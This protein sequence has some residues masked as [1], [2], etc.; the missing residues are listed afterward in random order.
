MKVVVL[1]SLAYSL[2]NFRATLLRAMAEQG[3]QIL[4]CAPDED[5]DVIPTLAANG[6]QFRTIPMERAGTNPLRDLKTLYHLVRLFRVERPDVILAYTQKP[7]I[8]GGMAARLA[9]PNARFYAMVSGLGHAFTAGGGGR[10]LLR[11][12][13]IALFRIA[14][15]RA[16]CIFVFNDCDAGEMRRLHI[17][18]AKH[19]VARVAGSGIDLERFARQPVPSGPPTFLMVARILRD[20]GVLEFIEAAKLIRARHPAARFQLLG[21]LDTGARGFRRVELEERLRDSGVDYLGDTRDV[22]PFL[23][24]STI[25]VLPSYYREGLPRT[26]L[27]AMATGRAIITTDMHGCRET[28]I[29][30]FNGILVQPRDATAL[31]QAMEDLVADPARTMEMGKRSRWLAAR[32]FDVHR[33]NDMLLTEMFDRGTNDQLKARRPARALNDRRALQFALAL[34]LG[35][36]LLPLALL[37]AIAAAIA[38]GGSVLLVQQ[39]AGKGATNFGLI[40]FRTM[41]DL[42]DAEGQL[43][44]DTLRLNR[45]GVLLRRLRLDELPEIYN[46]LRGDM[47]LIGPRPL[48]PSTIAAM[49]PDGMRRCEVSPG[50]TGWAQVNGNALLSEQ[51]KLALDL[52][53]IAHRSLALDML[54]LWRTMVMVIRGERVNGAHIRRAYA[55]VADRGR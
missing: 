53:Y 20:K 55:G 36:F 47:A 6:I 10:A 8:Y 31:A 54:I 35:L 42:Y 12:C 41:H 49:G 16:R 50:L 7:I 25:F 14:I 44:P 33:V 45:L 40:K 4:A 23:A 52:W 18:H 51:E 37:T 46:I 9:L 29:P 11:R 2:V 30:G 19:R 26:L 3:H 5:P 21:W 28:V 32:R 38:S 43:L 15:A 22:R 1:A 13:L 24:A 48:L 27:E 34:L 39:R 17:L